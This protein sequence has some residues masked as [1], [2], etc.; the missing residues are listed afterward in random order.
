MGGQP[1][2]NACRD[3]S[4]AV[5]DSAQEPTEA[6]PQNQRDAVEI[7][8]TLGRGGCQFAAGFHNPTVFPAGSCIQANV[9]LGIGTGGTS[10]F[11]PSFIAL[12]M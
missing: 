7:L 1:K 10:I 11:P 9:P 3:M 12:S 8:F 2:S 5:R 6:T 4:S